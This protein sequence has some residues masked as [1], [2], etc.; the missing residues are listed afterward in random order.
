MVGKVCGN[1]EIETDI[2]GAPVVVPGRRFSIRLSPDCRSAS[3]YRG[4][5]FA[6][7]PFPKRSKYPW[8]HRAAMEAVDDLPPGVPHRFSLCRGLDGMFWVCRGEARLYGPMEFAPALDMKMALERGEAELAAAVV[9]PPPRDAAP[10]ADDADRRPRRLRRS[11]RRVPTGVSYE[12]GK[13]AYPGE[14]EARAAM[15]SL[16]RIMG[17]RP[18]CAR[19]MM[20]YRCRRCGSWHFGHRPE[21]DRPGEKKGATG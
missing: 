16:A 1:G 13:S 10:P 20:A 5:D 14:R 3:I 18:G 12:C 6:A 7:G 9:V 11:L 19:P 2:G 17:E 4:D 21:R 8:K 15:A